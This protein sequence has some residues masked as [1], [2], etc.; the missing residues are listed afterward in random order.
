MRERRF[1]RSYKVIFTLL[2]FQVGENWI[3]NKI[4]SKTIFKGRKIVWKLRG[5]AII[6]VFMIFSSSKNY[7]AWIYT[8]S[9][10]KIDFKYQNFLNIEDKIPSLLWEGKKNGF[11]S[12]KERKMFFW[13]QKII[14]KLQSD[15]F[16]SIFLLFHSFL[17]ANRN[18]STQKLREKCIFP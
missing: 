1:A 4:K 17:G 14:E 10:K 3:S 13:Y 7:Q 12:K 2:L 6:M 11:Q 15:A 9:N 8:I 16:V 5:N 18:E